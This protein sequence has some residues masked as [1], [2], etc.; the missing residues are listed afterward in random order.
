MNTNIKAHLALLG[1]AL[2]YGGN[3][4]I[5]KEVMGEGP[6]LSPLALVMLRAFAGLILFRLIH[7][8]FIRER[9]ERKDL[10]L[11]LVAAVFGIA[12]NQ[13]FFMM[14]LKRTTPINA[15]LI[16]T[17]TPILVLI[18]SSL[19]L[20]EK[21][22]LRKLSGIMLGATGAIILISYGHRVSFSPEG[23]QGDLMV[24]ANATAFGI[25]LV[26]GRKLMQKYHPITVSSWLFTIG[27]LYILPVGLPPLVRTDW[28]GF[29]LAAWLG[30][31]YVLIGT[32]FL[33]YLF[34]TYAL[35]QVPPSVVSIYIYL[36]PL[37]AS[38]LSLTLGMEVL[39]AGKIG[40]GMLI[41]TG[42]YLVSYRPRKRSPG[43]P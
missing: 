32:T 15:S 7:F 17:S 23:L 39:T 31:G 16:M 8:F 29:T 41:F 10:G 24:L 20:G 22:T 28:S 11:I 25:F 42:V 18:I 38:L 33:A 27:C 43:L 6:A 5:A 34:N 26:I 19:L 1:V 14:G 4:I 40:A 21:I 12:L 35:K 2:I 13:I 3:Y 37:F 36:Q 9:I 30:V